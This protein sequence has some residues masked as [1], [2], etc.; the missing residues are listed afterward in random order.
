MLIVAALTL[1]IRGAMAQESNAPP[2]AP[3]VVTAVK[4]FE[5]CAPKAFW[6]YRQ[7]SI[8]Y[9]TRAL[10]PQET[11]DCESEAEQRLM[12]ELERAQ[13]QVDTLGVPL[14]PGQRGALTSLTFNAGASWMQSGLGEAVRAGDW[15]KARGIFLQ[16]VRANGRVLEGLVRRRRAE[17]A[18]FE[19]ELIAAVA[20]Q[21]PPAGEPASPAREAA[22]PP[23]TK[24]R[25]AANFAGDNGDRPRQAAKKAPV[26]AA[27]DDDKD[28]RPRQAA[29]KAPAKAADDDDKDDRPRR[30]PRRQ[31]D[32]K[33]EEGD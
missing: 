24:I 7:Y 5:G 31:R 28:D 32:D 9:G 3:A 29:K 20:E 14:T 26:K 16:Y 1:L 8:G 10:S 21:A 6:D 13:A 30:K 11:I 17:A 22:P 27:D 15:L 4:Q 25:L 12:V 18:W 19:E 23:A 2:L 33:D